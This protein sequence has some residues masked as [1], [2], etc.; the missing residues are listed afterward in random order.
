MTGGEAL[1]SRLRLDIIGQLNNLVRA[2]SPTDARVAMFNIL[3]YVTDL[4]TAA[5]VPKDEFIR[6]VEDAWSIY[7]RDKAADAINS[8]RTGEDPPLF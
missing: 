7:E 8:S 4:F 2:D 5:K 1:F 3:Q 6:S